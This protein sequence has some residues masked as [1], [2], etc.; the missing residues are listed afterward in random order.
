MAKHRPP[1]SRDR[2][3]AIRQQVIQASKAQPGRIP[4][5]ITLG[6]LRLEL[7]PDE[8]KTAAAV[9]RRAKGGRFV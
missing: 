9:L 3:E 5:R 4:R 7:E 1:G 6:G 8:V 2:D